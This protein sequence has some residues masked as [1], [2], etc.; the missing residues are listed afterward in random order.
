[1]AKMNWTSYNIIRFVKYYLNKSTVIKMLRNNN[2][3]SRLDASYY[4]QLKY[5]S[6]SIQK[7]L[8]FQY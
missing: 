5:Y 7:I 6:C 8:V 2:N 4:D 3:L 1:M